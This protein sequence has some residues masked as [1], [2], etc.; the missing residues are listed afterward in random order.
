[1]EVSVFIT[2][3]SYHRENNIPAPQAR[4]QWNYGRRLKLFWG[5][6][7]IQASEEKWIF[8]FDPT[9]V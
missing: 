7:G 2:Y 5:Q 6:R 4:R 3:P 9:V 1:M 8:I